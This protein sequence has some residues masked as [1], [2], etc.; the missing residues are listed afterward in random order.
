[1]KL[2]KMMSLAGLVAMLVAPAALMAQAPAGS[3]YHVA[4][5]IKLG[6]EGGWDYLVADADGHRLYISRGSHLMVL[7][8]D[9]DSVIGDIPNTNRIHGVAIAREFNRGFTSNGGDS[10][11]TVFDLKTLATVNVIHGTGRNPDAILYDPASKRVFTF[12]GGSSSATAIDAATG[13]IAGTVTLDGKPETGQADGH[14]HVFVNIE[15]KSEVQEFD[16]KSLTVIATWPL[17][18]CESPSG[19]AIDLAH[20]RLFLGCSNKLMAVVDAKTGRV[21]TTVPIGQGVDAN[22]FDPSSGLAFSS[23]GDGTLTIA[24]EDSPEKFTVVANVPT[25][26]RARTMALDTRTGRIYTV[27]AEFGTAPAVTADNPRPRP[28]M[29]PGSFTLLVLE[30]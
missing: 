9:R 12:N 2:K 30:K 21:V 17:A 7:D 5:T 15:D 25:L 19:M 13:S 1:M 16:S 22:G 24:H 23:N 27:T 28:P 10:S 3:T 14:G 4:K 26:R 6:G 29:V 11:V 18:P 8:T 20:S